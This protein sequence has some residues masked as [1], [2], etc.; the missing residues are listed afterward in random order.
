MTFAGE[1]GRLLR[2]NPAFHAEYACQNRRKWDR[3]S[4]IS[5]HEINDFKALRR[6][7]LPTAARGGQAPLG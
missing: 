4:F 1:D 7:F 3:S 2:R 5:F 6:L